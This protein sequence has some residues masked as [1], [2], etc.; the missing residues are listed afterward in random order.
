M[1]KLEIN[2]KTNCPFGHQ[3]IDRLL[4]I[5]AKDLSITN[6]WV[7]SLAIVGSAEMRRLNSIYR[8]Q[9][10]VTD[11]LSFDATS[12]DFILPAAESDY[13]GEVIICYPQLVQQ[14]RAVG[15]LANQEFNI[16]LL[17]GILHLLGYDHEKSEQRARRMQNLEKSV[18]SKLGFKS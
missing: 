14:A 16:L 9:D 13:L 8:H 1:I 12:R 11:V 5:L 18:L 17:H 3:Q 7:V 10:K 4:K 15:H 2:K 6:R